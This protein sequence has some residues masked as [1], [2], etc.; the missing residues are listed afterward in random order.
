MP[1]VIAERAHSVMG[2]VHESPKEISEAEVFR[3]GG[4]RGLWITEN[5]E[6]KRGELG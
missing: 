5:S 6:R 3:G 2:S 4:N 1:G